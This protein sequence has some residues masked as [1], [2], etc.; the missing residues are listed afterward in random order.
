MWV[1]IVITSVI[2]FGG[3]QSQVAM[4]SPSIVGIEFLKKESCESAATV[5]RQQKNIQT[6]YCVRK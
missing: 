1:L 6:A 2:Q 3:N 5:T 4:T